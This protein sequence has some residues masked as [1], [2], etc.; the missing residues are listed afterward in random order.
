MTDMISQHEWEG[1][2]KKLTDDAKAKPLKTSEEKEMEA[3][4]K[5]EESSKKLMQA[6]AELREKK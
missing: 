6:E 1:F 2:A 4:K 3:R 5:I